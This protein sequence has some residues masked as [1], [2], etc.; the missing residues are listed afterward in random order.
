MAKNQVERGGGG[1]ACYVSETVM[2]NRL[3]SIE[4]DE[5]ELL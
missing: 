4:D 2:Y 3:H 5:H 1:V